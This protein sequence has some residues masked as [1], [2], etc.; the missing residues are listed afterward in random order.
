[1]E[2][3]LRPFSRADAEACGA[4]CYEAFRQ[5]AEAHGSVPTFASGAVAAA[6][7]AASAGPG[8]YGVVAELDGRLVGSCFV[9]ER[10]VISAIGPITV[11]PVAQNRT[12]GRQL[13]R[14]V[15]DR[16]EAKGVVGVR[17]VQAAYHNRSLSL[18]TKLG[19]AAREPLSAIAGDAIDVAF[20]GYTVRDAT[21]AD[22]GA[23]K[24]LC[25][26]VHGFDRGDEVMDAIGRGGAFVVERGG[27]ITGYATGFSYAGHA[28][29]AAN[30]DLKALIGSGR[31]QPGVKF[32]VPTRNYE[33]FR[34]CLDQGFRVLEPMTLMSIGLYNEPAGAFL[35]SVSY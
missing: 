3:R 2:V 32:L 4:I 21:E 7:I 28:V 25:F 31:V 35:P 33:L 16:A 30:D 10:S 26:K 1:V 8:F 15:M 20:P 17:L 19:F 23:C 34:W 29:A 5:I 11:D 24:G 9:D 6:F 12:I 13:M 27:R 22:A 18:Y 14:H